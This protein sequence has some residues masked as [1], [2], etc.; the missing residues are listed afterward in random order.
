MFR[1]RL[2]YGKVK[3]DNT[4]KYSNLFIIVTARII[5]ALQLGWGWAPSTPATRSAAAAS[6]TAIALDQPDIPKFCNPH[7][8]GA[9][10]EDVTILCNLEG[11]TYMELNCMW[12][13]SS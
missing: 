2:K 6:A 11:L 3:Q 1:L 7:K 5:V 9:Q 13:W 10:G 8:L 12:S 4:N